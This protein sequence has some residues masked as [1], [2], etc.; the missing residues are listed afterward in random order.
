MVDF[1]APGD[2]VMVALPLGRRAAINLAHKASRNL[3]FDY[4]LRTV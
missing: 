2:T 1:F 4:R 3:N